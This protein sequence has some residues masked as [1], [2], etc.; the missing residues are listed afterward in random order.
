MGNCK[1]SWNSTN[2]NTKVILDYSAKLLSLGTGQKLNFLFMHDR[3]L[4]CTWSLSSEGREGE[5]SCMIVLL[6]VWDAAWFLAHS[7]PSCFL[8]SMII[9]YSFICSILLCLTGNIYRVPTLTKHCAKCFWL[10]GEHDSQCLCHKQGV[11]MEKEKE[12][13]GTLPPENPG[14]LSLAPNLHI[15]ILLQDLSPSLD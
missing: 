10:T 5:L 11:K 9:I 1:Q 3:G 6:S 7:A 14:T 15:G 13:R 8:G 12:K 2:L 4:H